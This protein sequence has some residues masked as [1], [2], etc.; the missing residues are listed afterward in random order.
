MWS[1]DRY[2]CLSLFP[3]PTA[4]VLIGMPSFCLALSEAT[5]QDDNANAAVPILSSP[6]DT[7]RQGRVCMESWLANYRLYEQFF[8]I[9]FYMLS[10]LILGFIFSE[11]RKHCQSEIQ[12]LRYMEFY[13]VSIC[14]SC[15]LLA[16]LGDFPC[17]IITHIL[18]RVEVVISG[19]YFTFIFQLIN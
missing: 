16:S 9:T 14:R 1:R 2:V 11:E 6:E 8:K 17:W 4:R 12:N 15:Y 13:N 18:A 7:D 5:N 10:V 3:H 19:T